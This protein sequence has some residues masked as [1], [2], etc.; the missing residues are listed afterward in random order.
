[1]I[2][3]SAQTLPSTHNSA[4]SASRPP[5]P[6]FNYRKKEAEKDILLLIL[7]KSAQSVTAEAPCFYHIYTASTYLNC[8]WKYKETPKDSSDHIYMENDDCHILD[9]F[10]CM[11]LHTFNTYQERIVNSEYGR[12]DTQIISEECGTCRRSVSIQ[13]WLVQCCLSWAAE[14]L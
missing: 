9:Y 5:L 14:W 12:A 10:F 7:A 6:E 4:R 1:M 8:Y 13:T 11:L 2:S 3:A